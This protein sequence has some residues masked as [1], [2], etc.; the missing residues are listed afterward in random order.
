MYIQLNLNIKGISALRKDF[1]QRKS[2]S[3]K[4]A[5]IIGSDYLG[6]VGV[7]P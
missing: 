6:E 2:L 7:Q 5:R 3:W 4:N 1:L